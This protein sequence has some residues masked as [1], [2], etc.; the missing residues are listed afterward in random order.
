MTSV[1]RVYVAVLLVLSCFAMAAP[2]GEQA[3][4]LGLVER[5]GVKG[6][7]VVV[8]GTDHVPE[9]ALEL[10]G[11]GNFVVQILE[12]DRRKVTA[13]RARAQGRLYGKVTVSLFDGRELPYADNSI[14]ALLVTGKQQVAGDEIMRALVPRGVV[15][16]DSEMRIRDCTAEKIGDWFK[17][18]KPVPADIDD[19]S[20]YLHGPD[21]NAVANDTVVGPPRHIQWVAGPRYGRHHDKM[22]SLSA[23][24]S[25][26]GRIF[27]IIDEAPPFSVFTAPEWR[28]VARDAF[29]GVLLWKRDITK[30]WNHLHAY[31]SGPS[32]LP[33]KLVASGERVF[34]VLDLDKPVEALDAATGKTLLTYANTGPADELLCSDGV[35]YVKKQE[36]L[37]AIDAGSGELIW[38]TAEAPVQGSVAIDKDNV[39]FLVDDRVVCLD[40]EAG[41]QRWRSEPVPRAEK[42]NVRFGPIM[43]VH[44]DV[45]LFAGGEKSVGHRDGQGNYSWNKGIDDTITALSLRDGKVL[46]TAP[47]PLSGYASEEDLFVIDGVVW[48]G[49][50]TSGHAKGSFKGYDLK[51]GK[52]VREF[53]PDVETYWIHHRCHRGKATV[54]YIIPS[55]TGI[56]YVDPKTGHW[57]INHWVRG[58]CVYGVMP[59]NGLTYAPQNPCACFPDSKVVGFNALSAK[60]SKPGPVSERLERGSAHTRAATGA[61]AAEDW[62]T[63][64]GNAARSGCT[65]T[66]VPSE[67]TEKWS[68]EIGGRLSSLTIAGGTVFVSSIDRHLVVALREDSGKEVWRH[69]ADGRVDSPPTIYSGLCIFGSRGGTI[70]ALRASD[71]ELAWRFR[72]AAADR[73]IVA[74]GQIESLWP[75]NGS[76]LVHDGVLYAAAGRSLFLDGGIR[77]VRLDPQTGRLLSETL[78]DD[79]DAAGNDVQQYARQHNMPASMP[80]ILSCNGRNVFMRSQAFDLAGNRRP[81]KALKYGG[82]PARYSVP[83]TQEPELAHLFSP[84]G[85]LDDSWWHRTYWVYGSRFLGGW[86]GYSAAGKVAPSGRI[87]VFDDERVYGYGRL[88]KFY[89]WTKP[90]EHH[91]FAAKKTAFKISAGDAHHW[92]GRVKMHPRGMVKAG[93]LLFIAGPED[94]VDEEKAWGKRGKDPELADRVRTQAELF[95][96]RSG[97]LLKVINAEDGAELSLIR[98]AGIPVFDGL[99]AANKSLYMSQV[100]GEVVCLR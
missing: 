77:M 21:N 42:Y 41:K 19:W 17:S 3:E 74:Y 88:P 90:I 33:R 47:H 82:N 1:A 54:N 4:M 59:A 51:S 27:Y 67:L 57:D 18:T 71:G 84:T 60:Q 92:T 14:N 64:R 24:I 44:D 62:S 16:S 81:L 30:W 5:A 78:M 91:L 93:G 45:V 87:L 99:I 36:T 56:E 20:H 98:T 38:K 95:A 49:E 80:D 11:R 73:R 26:N 79:K 72:V 53:D 68:T 85:F 13:A 43:I 65:P 22:S 39:V 50:T 48:C 37:M 61:R 6:G 69:L 9:L 12:T 40:R 58:A 55:R 89:R 28:L 15:L 2:T 52:P 25:E 46:W 83:A 76:V 35:L 63:Y 100:D 31:K 70:T 32:H 97:G 7:M 96:G 66:E 29:N 8:L 23:V 86:A 75:V 94:L 34:V 10:A